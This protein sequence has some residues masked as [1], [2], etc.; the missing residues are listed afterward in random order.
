MILTR[1]RID[2]AQALGRPPDLARVQPSAAERQRARAVQA[3]H[4]DLFVDVDRFE[5]VGDELPV[6]PERAQEAPR[7][8]V[9]RHVVIAWHH[10]VRALERLDERP[11]FGKLIPARALRQVP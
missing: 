8:V 7:E 4:R 10:Q 9:E 6:A 3:H 11:G 2:A 5:I 1:R